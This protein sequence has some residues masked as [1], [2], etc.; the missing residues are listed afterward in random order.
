LDPKIRKIAFLLLFDVGI[1]SDGKHCLFNVPNKVIVQLLI[2]A[3]EAL[4]LLSLPN[5]AWDRDRSRK[6]LAASRDSAMLIKLSAIKEV[7]R[8]GLS[9]A[10]RPTLAQNSIWP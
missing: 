1:F 3:D 7:G 5:H 9:R 2:S 8:S 4:G 6:A 10:A